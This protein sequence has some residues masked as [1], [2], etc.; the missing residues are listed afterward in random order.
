MKKS[1]SRLAQLMCLLEDGSTARSACSLSLMADLA[2]MLDSGV[3]AEERSGAGRRLVVRNPAALRDFIQLHF[4]NAPVPAGAS[5]RISGVARFRDTKAVASDLPEVVIV[6]AWHDDV[7]QC[8]GQPVATT[9]ATLAHGMF[10]FSLSEPSRYELRGPCAI[11]ENPAVFTQFE[12][13]KLPPRLALYG[14]GRSS[15]RLMDWLATQKA[16]DFQLLHLPDYDPV[17]LDEF[18]RLRARLGNRV[19]LHLPAN[20]PDLFARHANFGLLQNP[21]TQSLLAKLR[22]SQI[23]EVRTVLALIEKH[24]AGLEQEALLIKPG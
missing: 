6:R 12:R 23:A 17:G 5:S 4:P 18:T 19:L 24:N 20:L 13:L 10:S 1:E 8:D 16:A 3:V 15:N 22:S 14:H 21:S 7:L 11:V 2:P 9:T